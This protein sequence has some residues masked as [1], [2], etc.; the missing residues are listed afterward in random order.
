MPRRK[1]ED[2]PKEQLKVIKTPSLVGGIKDILPADGKYWD[3]ILG[4]INRVVRDHSFSKMSLPVIEKYE[5]FNHTLFKHSG[6]IEKE[7]LSFVDR[8]EKLALRPDTT[9]G[10]ARAFLEHNMINQ[11]MPLKAYYWGPSFRWGKV[12]ENKLRQFTQVGFEIIGDPSPAIDAELIIIS[13]YLLKSFKIESEIKLNSLGCLVCRHEYNK[14][15]S[16]FLKSKRSAVCMDCRKQAVKDPYRFFRCESNKC[17]HLREDA[18]QIIDWLCDSCRNHLFRVLEYLDELKIPYQLDPFLLRTYDYY[19]KTIFEI[20]TQDE[21]KQPLSIAGGGRW[22]YL[23]EMLGGPSVPAAGVS[24]GLERLINQMKVTR[25]EIPNPQAP[26]IF[27]AQL[28]ELAR[29]KA[30]AFFEQLRQEDLSVRANFSK[31]SLKE[32]LDQATKVGAKLILILG[33]KEVTEGTVI[34]REVDSGIQEVV[35]FSKVIPE[36]KKRLKIIK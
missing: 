30:F 3:Y 21:K 6:Q 7:V 28:S 8:G 2:Q 5:L 32:Q 17:Q 13:H 31:S 35:N 10:L 24:M 23:I 11:K 14:T 29:K 25:A 19:S 27:V 12:E 22:D 33:Q 34:L 16:G 4:E 9:P 1:K 36:V 20:F 15:L 18:P 26:D